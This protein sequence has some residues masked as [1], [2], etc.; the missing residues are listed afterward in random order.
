MADSE[1]SVGW[2]VGVAM[3]AI[4][5]FGWGFLAGSYASAHA[6]KLSEMSQDER[7]ALDSGLPT[8]RRARGRFFENAIDQLPNFVTVVSWNFSNRV[9]LPIV[10]IMSEALAVFGGI[11]MKSLESELSKPYR[12]KR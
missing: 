7:E 3:L 1:K 5:V 9:W 11:K 2:V 8:T 12:P 6:E 4:A 10:I